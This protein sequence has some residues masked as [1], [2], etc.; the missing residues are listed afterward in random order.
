MP[1]TRLDLE[2]DGTLTAGDPDLPRHY[3]V[4][5]V[6]PP[7]YEIVKSQDR[8]VDFGDTYIPQPELLPPQCVG[9][10]RTACAG[11]VDPVPGRSAPSQTPSAGRGTAPVRPQAGRPGRRRQ[12]RS[13]LLPVHRGA[14][15]GSHL[16]GILDDTANEFDPNSPQ[17]GEKYAPPWLPVSIHDWTGRVIGTHLLR[18]VR[19]LQR[20][21]ALHLHR[22]TCPCPAASRPTC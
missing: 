1:S 11:R 6:P 7:G 14:H 10:C 18:R 16:G 2:V 21:G 5:A 8:N 19:A 13:R 22:R 9:R 15:R 4:E 20:P 12:R 3:I 17:F